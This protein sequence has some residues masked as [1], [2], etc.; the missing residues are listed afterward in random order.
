MAAFMAGQRSGST[1]IRQSWPQKHKLG[2]R[3][4]S[5]HDY[6]ANTPTTTAR[7]SRKRCGHGDGARRWNSGESV[8]GAGALPSAASEQ[9][10]RGDAVG[11]QR[12]CYGGGGGTW[13]ELGRQWHRRSGAEL[14]RSIAGERK[15]EGEAGSGTK[16]MERSR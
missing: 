9:W 13:C 3:R 11:S 12:S 1:V 15:G 5:T 6:E 14:L 8:R 16:G 2:L 10:R 4:A 7:G